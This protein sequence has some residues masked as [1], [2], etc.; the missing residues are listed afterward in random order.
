MATEY[1]LSYTASE[2]NNKLGKIDG[3]SNQITEISDNVTVLENRMNT[4][5]A[6]PEGSTT[7]DAEII[8]ARIGS[9]GTVYSN[10]GEHIRTVTNKTNIE[11]ANK[12]FEISEEVETT[13]L[14]KVV[15][16]ALS[17]NSEIGTS[18]SLSVTP[19]EIYFVKGRTY[20]TTVYPLVMFFKDDVFVNTPI[21][22]VE[23][24]YY[25][26]QKIII[27]YGVNRVIV[28][29]AE[30]GNYA[31]PR[32]Y[33][34]K[35]I[36]LSDVNSVVEDT[37]LSVKTNKHSVTE[38]AKLKA[39]VKNGLY[40]K[41]KTDI[42]ETDQY[43]TYE[44]DVKYG[45]VVWYVG[46]SSGNAD[47]Y[48]TFRAY[49][50]NGNVVEYIRNVGDSVD[51]TNTYIVPSDVV[52]VIVTTT[53]YK[54]AYITRT[55]Y[56]ENTIG[57]NKKIVW[58]GTSIPEGKYN[59]GDKSVSYPELIG[60]KLGATVFNES[61]G[62][63]K[64]HAP[65]YASVVSDDNP[66][67]VASNHFVSTAKCISN[68][69][70]MQEWLIEHY[71]DEMFTSGKLGVMTD[72]LKEKIR[73]WS[74]ERKIDKYLTVDTFP[75]L[76][77]FDFGRNDMWGESDWTFDNSDP[78]KTVNASFQSA[79]N[80]LIKHIL[81][82][83]PKAKIVLIG[84]YTNQIRNALDGMTDHP[85]KIADGQEFVSDYW[86]IPLFKLWEKTG[87]SNKTINVNGVDMSVLASWLPDKL[88]P[89]SD[90]TGNAIEHIADI[91]TP[92][93]KENLN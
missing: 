58:F 7:G 93:I 62:E 87:W 6:L 53:K 46:G 66:Y 76:F 79:M 17:F 43:I 37:V 60:E 68:P 13:V 73:N 16:P 38:N 65:R 30:S 15:S 63:S 45:D 69:L 55:Y 48:D 31:Y 40:F 85:D 54:T 19:N 84:Y 20:G 75:D 26:A 74:Y 67:G 39:I 18:I 42:T 22:F 89:H 36:D 51:F 81:E 4:F 32:V 83:N 49:D 59:R 82:Y 5:T 50:S 71:D 52:K 41:N 9:D 25:S 1:K 24:E 23:N 90:T 47:L 78:Y 44:I 88:H 10:L 92:F 21:D 8:D 91:L 61:V 28:N 33:K 14:G 56:I 70:G 27:P 2:I 57:V 35:S 11:K 3:H 80:F 29:G 64:V 72:E 77:V 34:S 12:I 86:Q